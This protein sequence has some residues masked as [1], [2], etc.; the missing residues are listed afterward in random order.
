MVVHYCPSS[1]QWQFVLMRLVKGPHAR[2]CSSGNHATIL[3]KAQVHA[4]C[5]CAWVVAA[6]LNGCFALAREV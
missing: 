3:T 6:Y 4:A 2:P 1:S 5:N